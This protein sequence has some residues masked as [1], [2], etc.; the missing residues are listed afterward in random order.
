MEILAQE[1]F[2]IIDIISSYDAHLMTIKGWSITVGLAFIGYAF[3]QKNKKLLLLC[4]ASAVCFLLVDAKFKQYQVSYYPRM[5]A[6]EKCMEEENTSCTVLQVDRSWTE[7][8]SQNGY[9]QQLRKAGVTIPHLIL[10]ILAL[11]LYF[12]PGT[13]ESR[14]QQTN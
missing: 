5:Q 14:P 1:Y 7:A 2:K 9:F 4:C 12:I 11:A 13:V 6:I 10:F 3:Q 8:K